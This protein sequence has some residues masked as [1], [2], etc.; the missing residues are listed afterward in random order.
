MLGMNVLVRSPLLH[1]RG[2]LCDGELQQARLVPDLNWFDER[3][4]R[5]LAPSNRSRAGAFDAGANRIGDAGME[6]PF[7]GLGQVGEGYNMPPNCFRRRI[8]VDCA[9]NRE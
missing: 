6:N 2:I 8:N 9:S 7:R 1:R 5:E 3:S 4:G